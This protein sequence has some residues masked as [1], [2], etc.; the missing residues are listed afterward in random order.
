[1]KQFDLG[2]YRQARIWLAELPDAYSFP[3]DILK[4]NLPA[5]YK[6][7]MQTQAAVEALVPLGPRSK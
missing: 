7:K 2:K 3:E 5:K 1:M 4:F 6:S